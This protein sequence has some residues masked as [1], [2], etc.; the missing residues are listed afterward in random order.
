MTD[1]NTSPAADSNELAA[2]VSATGTSSTASRTSYE[3]DPAH[4][5]HADAILAMD[6]ANVPHAHDIPDGWAASFTLKPT[7]L[8]KAMQHEI[9]GQLAALGP[10]S[11]ASYEAKGAELTAAAMRSQKMQM[12]AKIGVGKDATPYH[13]ELA[14]IARDVQDLSRQFDAYQAQLEEVVRYDTVTDPATGEPKPVP[15]YAVT[16]DRARGYVMQQQ[17]L[18]RRIRLL[19]QD[20]GTP[21]LEG[22]KRAKQAMYESVAARVELTRQVT[23]EAEAKA[24]AVEINRKRRITARAD[25]LARLQRNGA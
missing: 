11:S 8:P 3:I 1:S 24:E 9:E 19:V 25:S 13:R 14:G 20:D 17:D 10:M 4:R 23:E 18:S 21:G 5:H 7:A 22:A 12:I 2:N 15:V 16:G 6:P